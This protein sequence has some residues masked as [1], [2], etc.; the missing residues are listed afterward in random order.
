MGKK[1][2]TLTNWPI[3]FTIMIRDNVQ[4]YVSAPITSI[5]D[6]NTGGPLYMMYLC[7]H[8]WFTGEN[9]IVILAQFTLCIPVFQFQPSPAF[10]PLGQEFN[11]AST[12]Y[13]ASRNCFLKIQS[14]FFRARYYLQALEGRIKPSLPKPKQNQTTPKPKQKKKLYLERRNKTKN[15][16]IL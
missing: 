14:L 1:Q 8:L 3:W 9:W 6:S 2:G 15:V 13:T 10:G 7:L 5:C 12:H 4:N 11:W 16:I